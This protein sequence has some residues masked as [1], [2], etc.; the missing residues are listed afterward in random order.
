VTLGIIDFDKVAAVALDEI[1]TALSGWLRGQPHD[2]PAFLNRITEALDRRRRGCDVGAA[3]PMTMTSDLAVLHRR[4]PNSTDRF[5]ADLAVTVDVPTTNFRKTAFFQFKRAADFQA[6]FES[7]Q[8]DAARE[9]GAIWDR[10]YALAIDE[11][12]E[13]L[14]IQ[15][16]NEVAAGFAH[17]TKTHKADCSDWLPVTRWLWLWLTCDLGPS[18]DPRDPNAVEPLLEDFRM[19]ISRRRFFGEGRDFTV[20]DDWVPARSWLQMFF[21]R[22]ETP[23]SRK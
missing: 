17:G 1:R 15:G 5:G 9:I 6:V 4:G 14:R 21:Q 7:S 13:V 23:F 11:T 22:L 19:P 2:E 12:R 3:A 20:P 8:F 18:S 10:S 16:A